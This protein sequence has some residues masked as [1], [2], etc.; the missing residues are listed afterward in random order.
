[1]GLTADTKELISH[2]GQLNTDPLSAAPLVT[3]VN[4]YSVSGTL[5]ASFLTK[6]GEGADNRGTR[7]NGEPGNLYMDI[8]NAWP[9]VRRTA[10]TGRAPEDHGTQ[11]QLEYSVKGDDKILTKGKFG[12][13]ILG[14]GK[15]DVDVSGIKK[16]TLSTVLQDRSKNKTLFWAEAVLE[17][18]QGKMI[19]LS[20]LP[21]VKTNVVNNPYGHTKDYDNGRINISGLDYSWGLSAEPIKIGMDA[22][23]EYT[24]DLS[25][26]QAV[27]LKTVIGGDYPL[28]DEAERRITF[29][30]RTDAPQARFLSVIEPFEKENSIQSVVAL[31]A[32][33]LIIK[34]KDG[35]EHRLFF[36]GM[37]GEEDALAVKMQEWKSGKLVREEDTKTK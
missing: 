6:F 18:S 29:G 13:W 8:Y 14:E 1:M 11:R 25:G 10:F 36:S 37:E 27:R 33:E 23:A 12:A 32:D 2:K 17:T 28:G 7:I 30:V 15:V 34:L 26:L 3:D 20:E 22:P 35:R 31:S 16:L 19:P 24:F 5:K 4:R 21:V 9:N